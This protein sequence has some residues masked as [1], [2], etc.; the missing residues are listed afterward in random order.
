MLIRIKLDR[1]SAQ[2]GPST[3]VVVEHDTAAAS[4]GEI[5]GLVAL[6]WNVEGIIVKLKPACT[7]QWGNISM[8]IDVAVVEV[9]IPHH[10]ACTVITLNRGASKET[11]IGNVNV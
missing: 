4:K 11:G 7:I 1:S 6:W 9:T 2:I 8:L 3:H 10:R 5:V